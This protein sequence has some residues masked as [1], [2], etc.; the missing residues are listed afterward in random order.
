MLKST[1][2]AGGK[3]CSPEFSS[4]YHHL[5]GWKY[6]VKWKGEPQEY[7]STNSEIYI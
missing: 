1:G 3:I 7:D 6:R 5:R 4:W 2:K